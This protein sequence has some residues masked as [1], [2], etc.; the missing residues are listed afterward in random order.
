MP[1]LRRDTRR[2]RKCCL[3][4][5]QLVERPGSFTGTVELSS[6]QPGHR[7]VTSSDDFSWEAFYP[8]EATCMPSLTLEV[9]TPTCCFSVAGE[10][11]SGRRTCIRSQ[12]LSM[13]CAGAFAG[14]RQKTSPRT[15]SKFLRPTAKRFGAGQVNRPSVG[16]TEA[17]KHGRHPRS[18]SS[19]KHRTIRL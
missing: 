2:G 16:P 3:G 18:G 15:V 11:D 6:V 10:G 17:G 12:T 4:R 14:P 9:G 8:G 13:P 19:I 5:D 1:R 7:G